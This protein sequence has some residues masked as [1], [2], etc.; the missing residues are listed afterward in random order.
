MKKILI[1]GSGGA[2]KSTFARELGDIIHLP[3]IHLDSHYWRPNWQMPD[4][5]TWEQQVKE[6]I[7]QETWIMDGNYGSTLHLRLPVA[8]TI[9]FLDYSRWLCLWR[10]CK[11][12]WIYRKKTRKDMA[13]DCSEKIDWEFL[14]YIW[15]YPNSRKPRIFQL[16]EQ[17]KDHLTIHAFKNDGEKRKFLLQ[18]TQKLNT[19]T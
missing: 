3:V 4:P 6:L 18:M 5:Q 10:V 14:H 9:F 7:K 16:L 11:R 13:K 15:H 8:D 17:H 19:K 2:G 1:L 12:R